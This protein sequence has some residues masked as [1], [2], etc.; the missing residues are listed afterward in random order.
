MQGFISKY[1]AERAFGFIR[2]DSSR[3]DVFFHKTAMVGDSE[4]KV[5]MVVEFVE[6]MAPNGRLRAASVRPI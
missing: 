5:D 3:T 2:P 4:P 6:E 1:F